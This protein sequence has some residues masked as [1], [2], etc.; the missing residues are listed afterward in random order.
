MILWWMV[1]VGHGY[2]PNKWR[3][4]HH[5]VALLEGK[6]GNISA[7]WANLADALVDGW[8]GS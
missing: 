7:F 1:G 4:N 3:P 5:E 8:G 2:L 6:E